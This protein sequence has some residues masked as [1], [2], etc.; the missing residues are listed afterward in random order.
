MKTSRNYCL[1]VQNALPDKYCLATWALPSAQ[2][3]G[4]TDDQAVIYKFCLKAEG[5]I[6]APVLHLLRFHI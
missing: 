3:K 1:P 5:S 2:G 4:G 6:Y